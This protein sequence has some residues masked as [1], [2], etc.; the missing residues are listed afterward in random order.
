MRHSLETLLLSLN[1]NDLKYPP[2]LRHRIIFA[3]DTNLVVCLF[4]LFFCLFV[5][6]FVFWLFAF[7]NDKTDIL[8]STS[9]LKYAFSKCLKNKYSFFLKPNKKDSIPRR[10]WNWSYPNLTYHKQAHYG[11]VWLHKISWIFLD[12]DFSWKN[13]IKFTENNSKKSKKNRHHI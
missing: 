13:H 9:S 4:C 12:E 3:E 7:S 2:D 5:F 1:V 6:V 10:S 11:V 8:I